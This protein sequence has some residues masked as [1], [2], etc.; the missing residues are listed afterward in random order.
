[1]SFDVRRGE[2]RQYRPL[3]EINGNLD[4]SVVGFGEASHLRVARK[5]KREAAMVHSSRSREAHEIRP[6]ELGELARHIV[7]VVAVR[8]ECYCRAGDVRGA[9]AMP[10]SGVRGGEMRSCGHAYADESRSG[11]GS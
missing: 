5:W 11:E 10:S 4:V 7:L 2:R 6:G 3:A 8:R 9:A 1:M